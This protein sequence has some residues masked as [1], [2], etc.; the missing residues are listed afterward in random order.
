[1]LDSD[2]TSHMT[3]RFD[4]VQAQKEC[5]LPI[6]LADDETMFSTSKGVRS[7]RWITE[8]GHCKFS[9]SVVLVTP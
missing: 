3:A 7:V 6:T 2:T 4:R 9:L 1:M 8:K 5:D